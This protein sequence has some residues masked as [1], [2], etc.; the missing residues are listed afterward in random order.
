M[1]YRRGLGLIGS[2][3]VG[4]G[5]MYLADPDRGKRR[6]SLVRDQIVSANKKIGRF[7]AGTTED[8]KNRAYG[9]YCE[10]KSLFGSS[11][12]GGP[13]STRNRKQPPELRRVG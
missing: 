5:I 10:A 3:C 11:C 7:A 1:T 6:L 2:A 12:E 8:V 13:G 4:A 9:L